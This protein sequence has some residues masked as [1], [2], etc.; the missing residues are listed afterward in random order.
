MKKTNGG[1][2]ED[3][4]KCYMAGPK[5]L[6]IRDEFKILWQCEKLSKSYDHL[7]SNRVKAL[8]GI[9]LLLFKN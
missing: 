3:G 4:Y 5:L 6:N 1:E 9:E 2:I 7:K 8:V